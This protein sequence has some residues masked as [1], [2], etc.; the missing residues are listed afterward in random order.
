[1]F[2]DP[3]KTHKSKCGQKAEFLNINTGETEKAMTRVGSQR[4]RKKNW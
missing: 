2:T 4:H 1:L 3:Y